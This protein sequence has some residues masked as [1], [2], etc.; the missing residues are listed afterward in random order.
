MIYTVGI[1]D[2]HKMFRKGLIEIVNL[3]HNYEVILDAGNGMELMQ[4]LKSAQPDVLILDL[5]MPEMDGFEAVKKITQ[6]YPNMKII[7]L[8]MYDQENFVLHAFQL[9]V[10]GYLFKNSGPDE[11]KLALDKVCGEGF[12]FTERV[13]KVLAKGLRK[14][15]KKPQFSAIQLSKLELEILG[16]ICE[17]MTTEEI[18]GKVFLAKR[19]VEGYRQN[20]TSKA[21]VKNTASLVTWAFR[22][23]LIE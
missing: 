14:R 19:T 16:Y 23:G 2:D 20:I 9:G 10:H 22:N 7:V 5:K 3:L 6:M 17:G 4:W 13:G 15:E 12:Y 11:L 8:S 18:A 21:G 1:A